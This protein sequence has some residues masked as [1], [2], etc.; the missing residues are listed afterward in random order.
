MQASRVN[1]QGPKQRCQLL[2][3]CVPLPAWL[4][5]FM[6]GMGFSYVRAQ[7]P[8]VPLSLPSWV[9]C[10]HPRP[11][12][13]HQRSQTGVTS[14]PEAEGQGQVVRPSVSFGTGC[15]LNT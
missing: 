10:D 3:P 2:T 9:S 7:S 8:P 1:P 11:V 14:P 12:T 6:A 13:T 5:G 15:S 4:H